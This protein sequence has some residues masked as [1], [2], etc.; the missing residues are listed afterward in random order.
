MQKH[1]KEIFKAESIRALAAQVGMPDPGV[2][3]STVAR[4]NSFVDAR[5][6]PEFGQV[7]HNLAWKCEKPPFWAATGSPALHHMCGGLR[8]K[9]TTAQVLDRWNKVIPSLYAAGE[10]AGGVH[11]TNRLGGNAITD[12]IVF[13]RLA[14]NMAAAEEPSD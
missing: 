4:Y 6:D 8:T 1:P 14:G 12:C 9:A 13:G 3:E 11:G 5:N 7:A 10:I 2:L